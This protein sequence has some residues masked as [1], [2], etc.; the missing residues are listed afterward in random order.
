MGVLPGA[1]AHG[2]RGYVAAL[3]QQAT[4]LFH[5]IQADVRGRQSETAYAMEGQI[6]AEVDIVMEATARMAEGLRQIGFEVVPEKGAVDDEAREAAQDVDVTR[7]RR[8]ASKEIVICEPV[9]GWWAF[10]GKRKQGR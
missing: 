1:V 4:E 5:A 8:P 3:L 10:A 6:I 9:S 2:Q 7:G